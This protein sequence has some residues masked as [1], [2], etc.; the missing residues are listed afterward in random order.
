[1]FEEPLAFAQGVLTLDA[2]YR[3]RLDRA[4]LDRLTVAH[5]RFD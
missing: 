3:P 5:R 1:L 4:Q 2:G